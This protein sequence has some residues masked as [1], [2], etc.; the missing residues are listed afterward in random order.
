MQRHIRWRIALPYLILLIITMAVFTLLGVNHIRQQ[1]TI[2]REQQL[3]DM[4]QVIAL[5]ARERFKTQGEELRLTNLADSTSEIVE[6][7]VTFLDMEGIIVA[8]SLPSNRLP[9]DAVLLASTDLVENLAWGRRSLTIWLQRHDIRQP[10]RR[11]RPGAG[12]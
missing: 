7:D 2:R 11:S 6:M 12:L 3:L 9:A 10:V 1:E 4:A 5:Q 8:T